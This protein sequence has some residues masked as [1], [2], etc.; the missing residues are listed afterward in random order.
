MKKI[1]LLTILCLTFSLTSCS[2]KEQIGSD[3]V[4]PSKDLSSTEIP[5][6]I[7]KLGGA[8]ADDFYISEL[9]ANYERLLVQ[10][11]NNNEFSAIESLLVP[12]SKLYNSQKKL[13]SDLYTKKIQE[14]L[15]EFDIEDIKY[16]EKEGVYKVYVTEKIGIKY[17]DKQD[18][19]IKEFNWVYTVVSSND[20]IG[21]SDI[22]KWDK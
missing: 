8:K 16:M 14:K 11:I 17:P 12:G 5:Q 20:K 1:I 4:V 10:V 2:N 22:E 18:F 9:I 7:E 6:D 3:Q 13:V 19:E 21:L 15:V